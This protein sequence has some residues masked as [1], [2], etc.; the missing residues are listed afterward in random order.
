MNNRPVAGGFVIYEALCLTVLLGIVSAAVLSAVAALHHHHRVLKQHYIASN[1][2]QNTA[3]QARLGTAQHSQGALAGFMYLQDDQ[4]LGIAAGDIMA[5]TEQG[6]PALALTLHWQVTD[7][8]RADRDG[9]GVGDVWQSSSP[10]RGAVA[11]VKYLQLRIHWWY[12]GERYELFLN[13]A[14]SRPLPSI[15]PE[16]ISGP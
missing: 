11:D 5:G 15:A 14:L 7:W 3:A 13:Q 16:D 9:D 4:A 2:L 12:R 10:Y 8:F 1:V 6:A